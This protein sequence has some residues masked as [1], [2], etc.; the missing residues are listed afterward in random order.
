MRQ[1]IADMRAL[2]LKEHKPDGVWD[3]KRQ[4]G[5]QVEI[6]FIAQWLELTTRSC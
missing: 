4:Q 5:G 1:D 3:L 2:M 6:E